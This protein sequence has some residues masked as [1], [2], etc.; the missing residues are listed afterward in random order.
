MTL[1]EYIIGVQQK[2][3]DPKVTLDQ[4]NQLIA[5]DSHNCWIEKTP[6]IAQ[7]QLE[8]AINLPL[9]GAPI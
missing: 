4:V 8:N 5:Q 7:Q 2:T 6:E 1:K 9:A 3:I